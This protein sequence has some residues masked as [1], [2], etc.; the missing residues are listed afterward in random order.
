MIQEL[1][2]WHDSDLS[3]RDTTHAKAFYLGQLPLEARPGARAWVRHALRLRVVEAR[4]DRDLVGDIVRERHLL[5]AW[6][7]PPRT[8]ILSYL[9]G[10]EGVTPGPA[11][12]AAMVMVALLP[13]QYHVRRALG[14]GQLDVLTLVRLWR[15]DDLGPAVTP[16][17]TP[18]ALRRV[19]RGERRGQRH[20]ADH[21][22]P[23]IRPLRE[24]WIARKCREGGLRAEPRLLATYADPAHGHDGAT[25]LAAGATFCGRAACG[26]L[27][28]AWALVDELREPL[29]ALGLAVDERTEEA[30]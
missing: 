29:R 25:Y 3:R 2:A 18:E 4:R 19:V 5:R 23:L 1:P 8:L 21:H 22:E 6:P 9:A 30:A 28:F 24:E 20:H 7:V 26:K 15:A 17:L 14:L 12:A 16:D 27:L 13:N 11:G 10:L